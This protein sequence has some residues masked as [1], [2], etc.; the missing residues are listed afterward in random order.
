VQLIA[1]HRKLSGFAIA[2]RSAVAI[3]PPMAAT[4]IGTN[5]AAGLG[6]ANTH[7]E[8]VISYMRVFLAAKGLDLLGALVILCAGFFVARTVGRLLQRKLERKD[9]E[10]PVR[11]L[12]L[13]VTKLIIVAMTVVV[14]IQ[15]MGVPV[16][17]LVA[18][19]GVA[20][21]GV[22]LAMQGV[23]GNLVAGL[24]I[25]FTKPYRVGD[26]IE[27]HGEHGQV[28]QIELF[29][30][31]LTHADRSRII[32]PNRKIVGEI[33]HNYGTIRQIDMSVGVGYDTNV[34]QAIELIRDI[35]KSNPRILKELVP[36]VGVGLLGD[37]SINI[38][39]RPWVAVPDY[40]AAQ[41][42]IYQAIIDQFRS[43]NIQIP[44]PQ[45]EVRLVNGAAEPSQRHV[46]A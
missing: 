22:G 10:P 18:G 41:A 15:T 28:A 30:T 29:S 5:A 42:E 38:S 26:Y 24:T 27:I 3:I 45:R 40:G 43:R 12:I 37:S 21:V 32:I 7:A 34:P 46:A 19:I 8:S 17:S 4:A 14:A 13:R 39:V 6:Q 25:I 9:L 23:L 33:L 1:P 2:L 16:M 11:M 20:G 36:G 44:F 35:L 31:I